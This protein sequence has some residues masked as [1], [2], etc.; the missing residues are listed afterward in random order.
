M[1]RSSDILTQR[2]YHWE[3]RGRGWHAFDFPVELEPEF[4]PFFGH[5]IRD[6]KN[7]DD[8]RRHTIAS[9]LLSA[10]KRKKKTPPDP[11]D[12]A[13]TSIPPVRAYPEER[14]ENLIVYGILLPKGGRIEMED[15][16]QLLLMLS[17]TT[18]ALSFEIIATAEQIRLQ[19]T[20]H[21]IDETHVV[22][23]IKAYFPTGFF[24]KYQ[25]GLE[26]LDGDSQTCVVNFGLTE[27]FMRPL[28]LYDDLRDDPYIGLFA[29]L[30]GIRQGERGV[31][32][33]LFKG[34]VNP[35][36]ESILRSVTTSNGSSFFADAPEMVKLAQ[37][38]TS[39]PLYAVCIRACGQAPTNN[40]AI[41]IT[42]TISTALNFI[43]KSA[44]NSLQVLS[45]YGYPID[46][47]IADVFLRQSHRIGMLINGK[48]L[49]T[50]AH[51]PTDTVINPALQREARKTKQAPYYGIGHNIVLGTNMHNGQEVQVTVPASIRLQH[52]HIIGAT[53]TGKSTMLLSMLVQD[54]HLGNGVALLDPHGDLVEAVLSHIP[55]NRMEDVILVDPADS[56]YPVGFNIL[57]AHSEIEKDI[58]SSDLVAAFKR[59]ST[60]WGD[61]MNS[62]LAN[63]ILAF[64]E[65]DQ[66][67]T[68]V[69][70]RKFLIEKP[71][72]D[73]YLQKVQDQ[74]IVYYWH[75][76]YPLLK[77][78]SIGSILTRLDTFLRP[79]LIRN[80]VGQKKSLEF[81]HIL[82]S[83]KIL[84]VKLSQG[85]IGAENSFLLGTFFVSK[86]YQAAMARQTKS[87]AARGDFFF[88]ID[89]FQNFITPSM[90]HILSGARKYHLGLILA[91][92][93]MQQLQRYDGELA[94]AVVVNAGTRVCFRLGDVDARRFAGGFSYFDADDLENLRTGEAIARIEQPTSDFNLATIRPPE[95]NREEAETIVESVILQSRHR[96][97][98]K[99]E[100]VEKSLDYL[101]S[102]SKEDVALPK[103]D[104]VYEQW[105]PKK[106]P[107]IPVEIETQSTKKTEQTQ[108]RYLQTLIKR[109][110]ESRGYKA[111]IEDSTPDGK[112]RVDLSLEREGKRIACEIS[113]TTDDTW[114]VHNVQK[115]LLAGYH[116][117]IV[118][119]NDIKHLAR[120][121]EQ[122]ESNLSKI[123]F[124]RVLVCEPQ[125]IV[126]YLD[127]QVVKEMAKETVHKGYRIKVEYEASTSQDMER[128]KE[129]VAKAVTK[130]A[131]RKK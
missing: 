12:D 107:F 51:F 105:K 31:I 90:S 115:C 117:V 121:R 42:K 85:L 109:M 79:K 131:E 3:Q 26:I 1:E 118:C 34:A 101:G 33:I 55:K 11:I 111:I 77:S 70:L 48:E 88:Y 22:N 60:S 110:A 73:E 100:L 125:A 66:G 24:S 59:N 17:Y 8:G 116:E 6:T 50:I 89:E 120:I 75:N 96:Y 16:E 41:E 43:S 13:L 106:E 81:E 124:S 104:P 69:D 62:V 87:Q 23:Q 20:C 21:S 38:K 10:L 103:A 2:F 95:I 67:G 45:D 76:E 86:I 102:I 46:D 44:N 29:S 123:D 53:G 18:H 15:M 9:A 91:H 14:D 114:E 129:N 39:V 37:S 35:W 63:A 56:E 27:E 49:A 71:F 80:M 112:G 130:S 64:L 52:T 5:Y 68:L 82:D 25:E 19:I 122:L 128:K 97:G 98:T 78:S 57:Q 83:R 61:Q 72:R 94:S 74:H 126:E 84:L 99:K 4:H 32:Q 113:I 127:K 58:L 40:R 7:E 28:A 119:S 65:N 108:H 54:M 93:D 36:S 30:A 92:Q 47:M